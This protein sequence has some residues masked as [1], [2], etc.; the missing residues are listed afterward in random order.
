MFVGLLMLK[1]GML[2]TTSPFTTCMVADTLPH[3]ELLLLSLTRIVTA[4]VKL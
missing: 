2:P 3:V 1:F 4:T